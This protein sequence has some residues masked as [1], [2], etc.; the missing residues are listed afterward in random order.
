MICPFCGKRLE[1]W[2]EKVVRVGKFHEEKQ[3]SF[4]A[5]RRGRRKVGW[6][7]RDTAAELE[8]KLTM[9]KNYLMVFRAMKENPNI[10]RFEN[11]RSAMAYIKR[12]R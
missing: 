6:S 2:A 8:L 1:T 11:L 3:E 4:G 5:G 10:E 7:I 12:T 9:T